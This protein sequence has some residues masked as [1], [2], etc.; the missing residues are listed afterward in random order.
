MTQK[1]DEPPKGDIYKFASPDGSFKRQVSSFRDHISSAPGAKF[2]PQKDR[3][4]SYASRTFSSAEIDEVSQVLY[5]SYGC[6]WASRANL[7]RTLK[8]LEDIIQMVATDWELFPDGWY[9][10]LSYP[11]SEYTQKAK[12]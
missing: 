3:Y 12:N 6:P 2:P 5:I 10:P 7:V 4:V 11:L 1:V 8:G 9:L